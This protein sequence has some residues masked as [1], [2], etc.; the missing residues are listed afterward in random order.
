[1]Y[2]WLTPWKYLELGALSNISLDTRSLQSFLIWL[3]NYSVKMSGAE[4]R[5]IFKQSNFSYTFTNIYFAV[6]LWLFLQE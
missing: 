1:M 2:V 4:L 6:I 5:L 3:Y